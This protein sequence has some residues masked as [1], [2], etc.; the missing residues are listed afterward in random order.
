[1][2]L[3]AHQDQT[4]LAEKGVLR[5]HGDPARKIVDYAVAA[6]IEENKVKTDFRIFEYCATV[7]NGG[8]TR[9]EIYDIQPRSMGD[10]ISTTPDEWRATRFHA[11][12]VVG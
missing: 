2:T 5:P 9:F 4:V 10:R 6:D 3:A 8:G 12:L 11:W 1:V 7:P